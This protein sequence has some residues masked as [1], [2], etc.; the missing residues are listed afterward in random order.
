[1]A[2][3][4]IS[5]DYLISQINSIEDVPF[6]LMR[7]AIN[8]RDQ[9]DQFEPDTR[10][11]LQHIVDN[12]LQESSDSETLNGSGSMA[13]E[14]E[15]I[16]TED[17]SGGYDWATNTEDFSI[18]V[19]GAEAVTVTLDTDTTGSLS[20]V[21][22]ALNDALPGGVE[23]FADGDNVGIRTTSTGSDESFTLASGTTDDALVTLGWSTGTYTGEDDDRQTS[24]ITSLDSS[25]EDVSVSVQVNGSSRSY[26][27]TEEKPLTIELATGITSE[28]ELV[29]TI[30]DALTAEEWFKPALIDPADY[31]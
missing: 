31:I 29:V 11:V 28:D 19:D 2:Y 3:N 22:S 21:V 30:S 26:T 20:D 27:V 7:L 8:Y 15:H 5:G 13:S 9:L 14:A 25:P 4:A 1:M 16:G 24:F 17:L 12:F 6:H 23:A 18:S 10:K